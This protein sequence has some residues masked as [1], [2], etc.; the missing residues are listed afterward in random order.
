MKMKPHSSPYKIRWIKKGGD[1]QKNEVCSVP[2]SIRGTYKD[3]IVCD[4]L[5]MDVC[6]IFGRP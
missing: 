5:D 4:V 1:A 3:L 2:L 6:H